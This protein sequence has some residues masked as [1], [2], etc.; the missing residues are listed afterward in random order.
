MILKARMPKYVWTNFVNSDHCG[1]KGCGILK[2]VV[3]NELN[4]TPNNF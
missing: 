2:L 1:K 3:K 4:V